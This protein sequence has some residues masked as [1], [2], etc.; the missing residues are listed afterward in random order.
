M[1]SP[2][3]EPLPPG[4]YGAPPQAGPY[5]QPSQ[6][7]SYPQ[8]GGGYP[9]QYASPYPGEQ[10]GTPYPPS[11]YPPGSY[12][13]GPYPLGPPP[14]GSQ[15]RRGWDGMAIA[16]FVLSIPGVLLFS[17][18]LAI[19]A[20]VRIRRTGNRGRGLAIAALA[21][22]AV[23]AVIVVLI[24]VAAVR[25]TPTRTPSGAV[26]QPRRVS[27]SDVR[28]GDCIEKFSEGRVSDIKVVPCTSAH[29][30]QVIGSFKL[31]NGSYPG[32]A[33][34]A[35]QADSRCADLVPASLANSN[36]KDLGIAY[37]YPQAA[38]WALGDRTVQCIVV[39]DGA[40]LTSPLPT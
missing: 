5:A 29:A 33:K 12:A 28:T 21:L 25:S 31:A 27:I 23:W 32:E 17:V 3:A 24:V 1:A 18:I 40:P 36:R 39:S 11:P 15:P 20:L 34:I 7:G 35:A 13:A 38:N 22:S 26:T 6:P 19:V 37:L 2:Y 10:A 8:A 9:G 4:P 30:G 14:P 16:A